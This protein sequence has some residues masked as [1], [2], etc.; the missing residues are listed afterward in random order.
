MKQAEAEYAH[1]KMTSGSNSDEDESAVKT[2]KNYGGEVYCFA[3]V[4]FGMSCQSS[5]RKA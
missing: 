5:A 3:A 2:K 4:G 1:G